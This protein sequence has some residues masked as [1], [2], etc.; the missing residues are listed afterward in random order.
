MATY[1]CIGVILWAVV[2]AMELTEPKH[3]REHHKIMSAVQIILLWPLIMVMVW[4]K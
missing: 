3:M 1:L 4:L 2:Y